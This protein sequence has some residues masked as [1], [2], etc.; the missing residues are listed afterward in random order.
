MTLPPREGGIA[1]TP[2][3]FGRLDRLSSELN[4]DLYI[5]RDD[6]TGLAFGGNKARKLAYLVGEA[7]RAGA[8][9]LVTAG[10]AQS[11]HARMTAAAARIAGLD[12]VLVLGGSGDQ[13]GN[14]LIDQ[15]LGAEIRWAGSTDWDLL[16]TLVDQEAERLGAQGRRAHKIPVGGATPVGCLGY[17]DAARELGSDIANLGDSVWRV[18]FAS[19]SGGTHAG[20][21]A[22]FAGGGPRLYSVA[23]AQPDELPRIVSKLATKTAALLG[24]PVTYEA[25]DVEVDSRFWGG[26]YGD[27]TPASLDAIR[28]FART[29]GI[30]LDPV[31]T[32]KAAAGLIEM[33]RSGEIGNDEKV[34]F[35]HTGGAPSLFA[36]AFMGKLV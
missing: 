27:E 24:E 15:V 9:T 28:L 31:Y 34:I 12:C 23:V 26:H 29:E 14:A 2:T 30:L 3:P 25:A 36:S 18:V 13:T 32:G 17:V 11:N 35:L 22:G 19:G 1:F 5:K 10:A 20:L 21:I 4:R 7:L 33:C 6:L 16:T 8:D